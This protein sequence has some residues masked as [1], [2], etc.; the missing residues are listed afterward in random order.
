[1]A[2]NYDDRKVGRFEEGRVLVST[3]EVCD[4]DKPFET[5]VRHPEYNG[6]DYIIVEAY[7]TRTL[8]ETGHA[9]WVERM[10]SDAL[11]HSLTDCNNASTTFCEQT[12][13]RIKPRGCN[14]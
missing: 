10:T 6:G 4:G 14:G 13:A 11:P 3:A 12:F 7:D 1:M 8:A 5:A 2:N 9:A